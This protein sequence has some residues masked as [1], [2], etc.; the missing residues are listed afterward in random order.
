MYIKA[1]RARK[2]IVFFYGC[3]AELLSKLEHLA[4][5][6][7]DIVTFQHVVDRALAQR[8]DLMALLLLDPAFQL[9]D[10]SGIL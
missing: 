5:F 1:Y 9:D 4:R 3:L 8:I 6:R 2:G 10:G 7:L